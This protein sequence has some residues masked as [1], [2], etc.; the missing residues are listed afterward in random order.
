MTKIN[1]IAKLSPSPS[2][3]WAELVIFSINPSTNPST[4]PP[5]HPTTHPPTHPSTRTSLDF[6][7][8]TKL[9]KQK[10]LVYSHKPQKCFWTSPR[11]QN[12]AIGPKKAQNDPK[13]RQNQDQGIELLLENKCCQFV[14]IGTTK[15][16]WP[17]PQPPRKF[18][19]CM[20]IP[21]HKF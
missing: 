18:L 1:I 14:F 2:Q 11:P 9:R 15:K 5:I 3:S 12:R 20:S 17:S 7:F 16:F 6:M 13:I 10:L 21:H 8:R 19:V 4:Q